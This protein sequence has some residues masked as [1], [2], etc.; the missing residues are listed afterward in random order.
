M[1]ALH[2]LDIPTLKKVRSG[3]VREIFDLGEHF[4]FVATD[5]VSA[6][7]C[8]LPTPIPDKGR[9]LTQISRFWFDR[10]A[11]EHHMIS[12]SLADL[13]SQ[14]QSLFPLLDGRFMIVKKLQMLPV[15]CVV[16][17]YLVGSG[18]ADYQK[19]GSV[20]G[21]TLPQ[22]MQR[23]QQ[24]EKPLFT[25][26]A[27]N[28][29]GHDENISFATMKEMIGDHLA[30]QLRDISVD[31]YVRARDIARE[32]GLIIADTKFEF[33]VQDGTIVL[34]DE[35]LT[36]DSSRYWDEQ[37]YQIGRNP[38]SFDKQIVRDH[39]AGTNWNK[40]PPAPEL[41]DAIVSRTRE[42]YLELAEK[43]IG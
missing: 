26:A 42:K 12:D 18:F 38:E 8:I 25:P 23:A 35:V 14:L 10:L 39:L 9:V 7:D 22:G 41:P 6:F 30:E 28:D 33:G 20:C 13:P 43:L 5:R 15:E 16:R 27:K 19:T 21:I 40:E 24:L 31:L 36:P 37:A 1:N 3:K 11:V 29:H 34:A 4:L 17:G 32:K 2:T